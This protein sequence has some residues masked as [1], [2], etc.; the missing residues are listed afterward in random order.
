L[1]YVIAVQDFHTHG[2]MHMVT[3]AMTEYVYGR[4]EKLD[5]N[6]NLI[7]EWIGDHVWENRREK[8]SFFNLPDTENVSAI[9]VNPQAMREP[10]D[11]ER[12]HHNQTYRL[13]TGR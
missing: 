4:R 1:P 2:A 11:L 3:T 6:G 7:I 12:L 9:I 13:F 5:Q 10:P 8:S